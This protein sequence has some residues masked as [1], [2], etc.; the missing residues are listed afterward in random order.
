MTRGLLKKNLL[1]FVGA[2][3]GGVARYAAGFLA[4]ALVPGPF[5]WGTFAVNVTGCFA[6]GGLMYLFRDR[7][8]LGPGHRL[9]LM[10]GLLGGYTTFSSFGYE[11]DALLRQGH[12]G[13]EI[14]YAA[15]S[16][17]F[18]L[19]AVRA[20][21]AGVRG[22]ERLALFIFRAGSAAAPRG[23]SPDLPRPLSLEEEPSE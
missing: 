19:A 4:G 14:V 6:M 16:A 23:T 21:R 18:G 9:F 3:L 22:L 2:G 8:L 15:A 17:L 5:P 13:L 11:S 7:G 20:G 1:V 10:V 12:M